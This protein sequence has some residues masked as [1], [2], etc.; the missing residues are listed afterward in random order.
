MSPGDD[1]GSVLTRQQIAWRR[2]HVANQVWGT[3][4]GR[5]YEHILPRDA[6]QEGLWP[7]IRD[8]APVSLPAYLRSNPIRPHDGINNLKSSW[9]LCANLYFPFG[10]QD[11]DRDLLA[12]FLRATVDSA[13]ERIDAVE[14]EHAESLES[15]LHPSTLLGEAG[16]SRGAGQTSPDLALRINGGRGLILIENKLAEHAFY[17]CSAARR[18]RSPRLAIGN[19]SDAAADRCRDVEEL[20]ADPERHCHQ[21]LLGRRYWTHLAP[22]ADRAALARHGCCPALRGGYQIFRQQALAEAIAVSGR[23]ETVMS[24]LAIDARNG[25]LQASVR[26]PGRLHDGRFLPLSE[27]GTLFPGRAGFALWTHQRWYDWVSR[28]GDRTR[29]SGWIDWIGERYALGAS[30]AP[31]LSG[32]VA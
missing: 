24:C 14:L 27:W 20:L 29:W 16:G 6:W 9:I 11:A 26:S 31:G 30:P 4:N 21:S 25:A 19:A 23:Y 32:G 17:D 2:A 5:P 15:G 13:V 3:W 10:W 1:F 8:G 18:A 28:H 12:G 22:R 7:G